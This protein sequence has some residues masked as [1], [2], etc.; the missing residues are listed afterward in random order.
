VGAV[1]LQEAAAR[2]EAVLMDAPPAMNTGLCADRL[3]DLQAEWARA[4][5]GLR[6]VLK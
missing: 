4:M 6:L 2:P 1:D 5:D 3:R